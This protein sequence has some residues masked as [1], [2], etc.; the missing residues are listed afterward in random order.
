LDPGKFSAT[1]YGEYQPVDTNDTSE[2]RDKNRR[3]EVLILPYQQQN[4]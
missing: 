1:G 4:E 2:G 3:V